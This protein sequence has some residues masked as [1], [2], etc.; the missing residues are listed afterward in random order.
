MVSFRN[1]LLAAVAVVGVVAQEPTGDEAAAQAYWNEAATLNGAEGDAPEK[2]STL[3]HAPRT[4]ILKDPYKG[5]YC[6][7]RYTKPPCETKCN[8][9]NCFRGFLNARDGSDGKVSHVLPPSISLLLF[10]PSQRLPSC[11]RTDNIVIQHCPK[12][13]F[14]F[15]CIWNFANPW[16]K[17]WAI[18]T[19]VLYKLAPYSANCKGDKDTWKD[20][21]AKV[22][23][24]CGCTLNHEVTVDVKSDYYGL[25]FFGPFSKQCH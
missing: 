7:A 22:D 20:V 4:E 10:W 8:R 11:T 19:G 21:L 13:A 5:S 1:I 15:C 17:Y 25:R 23:D 9:N 16:E 18:K 14:A 12:E 2:R 24:V 3:V 6:R